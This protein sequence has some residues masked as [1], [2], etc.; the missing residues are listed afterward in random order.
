MKIAYYCQH[1]LGIGHYH[2]SLEICRALAKHHQVTLIVGGPEVRLES[3]AIGVYRLPGL[4]MDATFHNLAPTDSSTTLEEVREQRKQMLATFFARQSPEMFVVELYPF[5]RKSFRFELDP[6][7]AAI[8]AGTLPPCRCYVSL[9]DILVERPTDREKFEERAIAT[10][11][12]YF[13]G[14]LIHADP[15]IIT[16]DET[17]GRVADIEIPRAYTGFVTSPPPGRSERSRWRKRLGLDEDDRLVVVS[18]GGGNVGGELLSA[19]CEAQRQL[20][21]AARCHMQIFTGPYFA[22]D[23]FAQ[24]EHRLPPRTTL[25]R[26]SHTFPAW[27]QAADLSISM[28]GYNTCMN[29][30]QAGVPALVLPFAENREQL[31][32]A[33]RLAKKAPISILSPTALAPQ[34]LSAAI[35]EH[36]HKP[37][38]ENTI[39]LDGAQA[40]RR[41]LEEWHC[42]GYTHP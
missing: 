42:P 7:L 16:L 10:L 38:H 21:G 35:W 1:V 8:R 29:I 31:L 25:S 3:D 14:L 34:P 39:N 11:N 4:Q 19:C 18:I 22:A 40:S 9:R 6:V 20:E 32:R 17:F 23:A 26:F 28:A 12:R 5:G 36:C 24:L 27:L 30:V 13:D 33:R 2:R 37:R 15:E 41:I